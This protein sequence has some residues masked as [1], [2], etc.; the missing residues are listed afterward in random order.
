MN[1]C[2]FLRAA[3]ALSLL[4]L[5]TGCGSDD[6]APASTP[7]PDLTCS[8]DA[9]Y[10]VHGP[11]AVG[12]R[13]LT[14]GESKKAM[15]VWYPA[16][17]ADAAG[18]SADVY[19]LRDWLT[20]ELAAKIDDARAPSFVTD[21][22]RELPVSGAER[23]PV[24]L[25]SHGLGG[26]RSQSSRIMSHLASW[27]MVVAAPDNTGVGLGTILGGGQ[28]DDQ[29]TPLL[30]EA[31]EVLV[32]ADGD[33]SSPF[34]G[35]IDA[36]AFALSAHSFGGSATYLVAADRPWVKAFAVMATQGGDAATIPQALPKLIMAG[37][38]DGVADGVQP[39]QNAYDALTEPKR[40]VVVGNA[41]HLAFS[42][43][44]EIGKELGGLPGIAEAVGL[45]IDPS[46]IEFG[47]DGCAPERLPPRD[48]WPVIGHYMTAHLRAA[49]GKDAS[50]AGY[51]A[52][53]KDCF[54]AKVL[55][56]ESQ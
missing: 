5:S 8:G 14:L 45:E 51:D 30:D 20:P 22:Y 24:V 35:K 50:V 47:T 9:A 23:F 53:A 46:I 25:F 10:A 33:A 15:E 13:T 16:A 56:W 18:K 12:V 54:G 31:H 34:F 2:H 41:G 27:G 40:F 7:Q 44:C 36:T 6:A 29:S 39:L 32:A 26:Y 48:A 55:K 21:A 11:Y 38:N 43:I 49:L 1:F 42:D 28:F 17:P 52:A 37:E 19:D 3:T 4:A